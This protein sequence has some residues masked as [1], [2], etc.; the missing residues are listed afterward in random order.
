MTY[1]PRMLLLGAVVLGLAACQALP[2]AAGT[3]EDRTPGETLALLEGSWEH[4][5]SG[6]RYTFAR[7]GNQLAL[8]VVGG[9][10]L[11]LQVTEVEWDGRQVRFSY[12]LPDPPRTIY[13]ETVAIQRQE[14]RASYTDAQGRSGM[15]TFRR[16][17]N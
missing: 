3:P 17:V 14:I 9:D 11:P 1:L 13:V 16:M 5:A 4:P 6:T 7:Q 12:A 8:S 15:V 10:N 2:P